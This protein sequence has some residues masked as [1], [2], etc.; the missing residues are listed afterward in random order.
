MDDS[1]IKSTNQ[2][3][4]SED[5]IIVGDLFP[6]QPSIFAANTWQTLRKE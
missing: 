2:V 6:D 5:V 1:P 4:H 3:I